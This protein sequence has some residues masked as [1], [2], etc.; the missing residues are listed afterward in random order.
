MGDSIKALR[1]VLLGE[2]AGATVTR[3][4]LAGDGTLVLDAALM[5][6]AGFVE[7]EKV[8]VYDA[9]CGTRLSM[10]VVSG[11]KG[12]VAVTGAAA[13]LVHQGDVVAV[14]AYGWVKEKAA[15]RHSPRRV[16]VDGQNRIASRTGGAALPLETKDPKKEKKAPEPITLRRSPKKGA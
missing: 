10:P 14:A 2:V 6:A 15:A 8:E 13:H 4:D 11:E 9:T 3:A 5:S 16:K 12:A 7:H 1:Q